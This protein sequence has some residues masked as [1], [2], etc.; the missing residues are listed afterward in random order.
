M[1]W[2]AL[3]LTTAACGRLHFDPLGDGVV[4]TNG[5]AYVKA[6]NTDAQD[7]FGFSVAL[8]ADG[9]TLAV[10]AIG[11]DSDANG[12]D[13]DQSDNAAADSGAVYIFTR[14]DGTWIPSAYVKASNSDAGDQFGDAVALSADGT[15]LAVGAFREAS[16]VVG[17]QLDN[18]AVGAGAV[19][20]FTRSGATWSQQAYLKASNPDAADNFGGGRL[21]ISAS[22]DVVVAGAADEDSNGTP[23]NNNVLSSGAAY[24]FERIGN[25][26]TQTA[27]LK[28]PNLEAMDFF[29]YRNVVSGDGNTIAVSAYGESSAATGVNGNSTDNSASQAGAVYVFV[30]SGSMSWIFDSYLK[31]SNTAAVAWFGSSLSIAYDGNRIAVGARFEGSGSAQSGAAY[32][33]DRSGSW[34]QTAYLKAS[35]AEVQDNFGFD[36]ALRTSG[37][38]LAV[39]ASLEDGNAR[40]VTASGTSDNSSNAAGAAYAFGDPWMMEL[41]YIKATNGDPDDYFGNCVTIADRAMAIAAYGEAS[42]A[43]GVGGDQSDNSMPVAGAVYVFDG[44]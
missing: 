6:T 26:W 21:S 33:F 22:G 31:A 13:G 27:Y 10:G 38:A 37:A 42:S 35:N 28:A 9:S 40:G 36:L 16:A 41:A 5:V 32:L 20:V 15:T 19:Y 14:S 30:R 7:G 4:V 39:S 1:R 2:L 3:V 11:E 25:V 18:T 23:T 8:S 34:Q 12:I 17:N 44:I 24:V 29:G 43:T